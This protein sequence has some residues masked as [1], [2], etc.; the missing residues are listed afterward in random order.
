M[1]AS[2]IIATVWTGP[3]SI[4]T[5]QCLCVRLATIDGDTG[6]KLQHRLRHLPTAAPSLTVILIFFIV[7]KIISSVRE[8]TLQLKLNA[9]AQCSAPN[10]RQSR[11]TD[12]IYF[13]TREE[14]WLTRWV[15]WDRQDDGGRVSKRN[16]K[17]TVFKN[18]LDFE[19]LLTS[20]INLSDIGSFF[21]TFVSHL[22]SSTVCWF[23]LFKLCISPPPL[24]YIKVYAVH[25]SKLSYSFC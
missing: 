24:F 1:C 20:A 5:W 2:N 3:F 22:F 9:A 17:V 16:V 18:I 21:K 11:I 6:V 25:A 23:L 8:Q 10:E 4:L 15:R 19:S 14:S 13:I 7:I 12:Q